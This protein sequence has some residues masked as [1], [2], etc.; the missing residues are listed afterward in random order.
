MGLVVGL[1][2]LLVKIR[3]KMADDEPFDLTGARVNVIKISANFRRVQRRGE[4]DPH[5]LHPQDGTS[6]Q[7]GEQD[8]DFDGSPHG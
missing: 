6:C 3:P 2:L 8:E 1:L 7:R 5:L 4:I